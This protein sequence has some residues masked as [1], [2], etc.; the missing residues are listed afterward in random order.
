MHHH[1][2]PLGNEELN[3]FIALLR[4]LLDE[5]GTREATR[6]RMQ[7][8]VL[9]LH[10]STHIINENKGTRLPPISRLKNS[11]SQKL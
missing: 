10:I 4:T 11:D 6:W 3:G 1:L 8:R 7:L 2:T 9:L 5:G